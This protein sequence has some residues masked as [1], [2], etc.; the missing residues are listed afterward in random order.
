MRWTLTRTETGIFARARALHQQVMAE[1][2]RQARER[3]AERAQ[4]A[5][6]RLLKLLQDRFGLRPVQVTVWEDPKAEGD[7]L[8]RMVATVVDDGEA[9]EFVL[10]RSDED[11]Y[12][13]QICGGCGRWAYRGPVWD[14]MT[15]GRLLETEARCV[16]CQRGLP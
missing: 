5:F 16:L 13:R 4:R 6:A 1:A 15:L 14:L 3:E 10:L 12:L 9:A 11:L 2:E 8:G 7:I